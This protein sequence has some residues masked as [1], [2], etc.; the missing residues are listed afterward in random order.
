MP[1]SNA[2]SP[3]ATAYALSAAIRTMTGIRLRR[4]A[5]MSEVHVYS[6][7][8]M[9]SEGGNT[10][11]YTG[12]GPDIVMKSSYDEALTRAAAL[13]AFAS[14]M[15]A[16]AF[17]GGSFEGGDIQDIAVKHGLLRIEQRSEECGEVCAC[18]EYGFPAE[19]YRKTDLVKGGEQ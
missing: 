12:G 3:T 1:A 18:R 9:V 6:V 15:I 11:T 14:E 8:K 13:K 19:C 17:E 10:I 2:I 5:A 7:R 4:V 16:A